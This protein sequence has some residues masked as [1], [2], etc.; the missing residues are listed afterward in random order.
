M[1][2]HI[3]H[4]LVQK[5]VSLIKVESV[6]DILLPLYSSWYMTINGGGVL[7]LFRGDYSNIT[8]FQYLEYT[9]ICTFTLFHYKQNFIRPRQNIALVMHIVNIMNL[10]FLFSK[11]LH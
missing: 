5:E 10:P 8:Y 1:N 3:K 11:H 4:C 9:E 2:P 7:V 6:P